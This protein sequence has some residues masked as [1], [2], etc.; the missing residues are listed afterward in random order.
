[1]SQLRTRGSPVMSDSAVVRGR[2]STPELL[3]SMCATREPMLRVPVLQVA[4]RREEQIP[5][6][7]EAAQPPVAAGAQHTT[8]E[9][10]RVIVVEREVHLTLRTRTQAH[11]AATVLCVQLQVVRGVISVELLVGAIAQRKATDTLVMTT[12]VSED[13]CDV[14]GP[15][16]VL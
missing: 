9:T 8:R 6:I 1:R 11:R 5:T 10:G 13:R 16:L 7:A 12:L 2:S 3:N 14:L 4:D 15:R